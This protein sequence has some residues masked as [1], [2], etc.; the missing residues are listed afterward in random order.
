MASAA[1]LPVAL[2][3]IEELYDYVSVAAER[4]RFVAGP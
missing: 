4:G 2:V 1:G 3:K